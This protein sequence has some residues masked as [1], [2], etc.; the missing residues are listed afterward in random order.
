MC[1]MQSKDIDFESVM[2]CKL[3]KVMAKKVVPNPNFKG[4]MANSAQRNLNIV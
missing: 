2:W 1:D 3:N 4:F